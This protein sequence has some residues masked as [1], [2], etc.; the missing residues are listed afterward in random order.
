VHLHGELYA[1]REI[2]IIGRNV[3]GDLKREGRLGGQLSGKP[4]TWRSNTMRGG[5]RKR[6]KR[7]KRGRD[8]IDGLGGLNHVWGVR[9]CWMRR[10][11]VQSVLLA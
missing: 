4:K 7:R 11:G 2:N 1:G 6:G 8:S 9:I 3:S 10:E 5:P